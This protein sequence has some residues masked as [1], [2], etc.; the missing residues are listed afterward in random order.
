M[1]KFF[2]FFLVLRIT[3]HHPA[4]HDT[5]ARPTRGPHRHGRGLLAPL[6]GRETAAL[7]ET[8]V[9]RAAAGASEFTG[10]WSST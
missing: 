4:N 10:T 6:A 5:D 3:G 7:N 2:S 8:Q 9:P 1:K